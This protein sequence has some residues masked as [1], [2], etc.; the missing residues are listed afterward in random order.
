MRCMALK[1]WVQSSRG[2]V[3]YNQNLRMLLNFYRPLKL[4]LFSSD[5]THCVMILNSW[6]SCS[7]SPKENPFC[8]D[9]IDFMTSC[10]LQTELQNV[11]EQSQ[12]ES[13]PST[14][15]YTITEAAFEYPQLFWQL[16]LLYCQDNINNSH[17]S[18]QSDTPVTSTALTDS[19][20]VA[21][22]FL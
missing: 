14:F 13:A 1:R 7:S 3:L 6:S 20:T 8:V 11:T 12:L 10:L 5:I 17:K 22:K 15:R 4:N 16:W 18:K 2:P 9:V 21:D 19:R